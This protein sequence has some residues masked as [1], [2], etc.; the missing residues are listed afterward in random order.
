MF[1]YFWFCWDFLPFLFWPDLFAL[2]PHLALYL[3]D[4]TPSKSKHQMSKITKT[5]LLYPLNFCSTIF[6]SAG[7]FYHFFSAWTFFALRPH[8]AHYLIDV[9]TSKS[10]HQMSKITKASLLYPLSFILLAPFTIFVR[11]DLFAL[12]L[13]L[14][15][16]LLD[17]TPSKCKHKMSKITKTPPFISTQFLFHLF[18]FHYFLFS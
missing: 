4:V 6:C 8:L 11:W 3:I 2:K 9:T 18:L 7:T 17:V 1:N 16:Y 5:P 15:H 12:K 14:A 13:H 10:K